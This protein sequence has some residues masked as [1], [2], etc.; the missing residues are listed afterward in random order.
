MKAR[1]SAKLKM[2]GARLG[3][4]EDAEA[5]HEG[6]RRGV[7]EL[8]QRPRERDAEDD[9]PGRGRPACGRRCR[10]RRRAARGRRGPVSRSAVGIRLVSM[11]RAVPADALEAATARGRIRSARGPCHVSGSVDP[12]FLLVVLRGARMQRRR[13]AVLH[14]LGRIEVGEGRMQLLEL[15]EILERRLDQIVDDVVRTLAEVTSV[16]STP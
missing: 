10:L 8:E 16:A 12:A 7:P 5:E 13:E 1:N 9:P 2:K 6:Q 4:A 15:L 14:H 11:R 3:I